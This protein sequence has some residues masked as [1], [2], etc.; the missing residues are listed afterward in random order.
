MI[1]SKSRLYHFLGVILFSS[2][3]LGL[4][5]CG[6]SPSEPNNGYPVDEELRFKIGQMVMIGFRGME[7]DDSDHIVADILDR[8]IGGVVLYDYDLPSYS[9]NRNIQS[10]DQLT[11]LI[12]G[13][14]G[15]DT[16]PLLIA[17]DQEG[18]MVNRLKES[19][20]F[21]PT[22]SAQH[23]GEADCTDTT[24]YWS[25]SIAQTLAGLGI[26][27]NFAPVVDLNV[28]P[29]CP[30]IGRKERSF[31]ADPAAVTQHA[32]IFVEE[33]HNN[34]VFCTLKHFPGHGSSTADSHYGV[35]DVTGTWSDTELEPYLDFITQGEC[36]AVMT[37][38]IFNANLDPDYPATL[39]FNI[40]T[41]L[42]R[43]ELGFQGVV[44]SDDLQMA[45]IVEHY[46][47][48][49]SIKK[50]ILAGVDILLFSNNSP[51]YNSQLAEEVIGVIVNLLEEGEINPEY[52]EESYQRIQYLKGGILF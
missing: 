36:D 2:A 4:A 22:V 41:G 6:D 51:P 43:G 16:I 40:I 37:A 25:A 10:P 48:R 34:G 8:H 19:Y 21:P 32:R 38:H 46:G 13:L 47:F 15:L 33:H 1:I 20:G 50:A 14:Q 27:L 9:Y 5:G 35:A 17:I 39:S 3:L 49:E 12:M 11:E 30:V 28:N 24:K 23:L 42:L 29:D 45:A 44:I 7:V 26:T 18:G 52:I 31:S